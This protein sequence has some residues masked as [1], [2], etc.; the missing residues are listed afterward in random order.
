ME[1]K[2]NMGFATGTGPD[3]VRYVISSIAH[4]V[5]QEHYTPLE[6]Y[7]NSWAD[8]DDI[9]D[10]AYGIGSYKGVRYGIAVHTSPMFLIYRK[11]FYEEAGLD[12]NAPPTTWD[13]L[14]EASRKL[15][16]RDGDTV[17]RGGINFP[18]AGF[19]HHRFIMF[20]RMNGAKLVDYDKDIPTF[21]EPRAVEALEYLASYNREGLLVPYRMGGGETAP[22]NQGRAA[23]M[24]GSLGNVAE[25]LRVHPEWEGLLGFGEVSQV[26]NSS[27]A[28]AQIYFIAGDTKYKDEGWEFIKFLLQKE[29]LWKMYTE[30]GTIPIRK[31]LRDQFVADSPELHKIVFNTLSYG[32]GNPKVTWSPL[33]VKYIDNAYEQA[34]YGA[35][36]K[37]ALDEAVRLLLEDLKN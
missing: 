35:D 32:E 18:T 16:A 22:F 34:M 33:F 29:T 27:F 23:Q 5:S 3:V 28:G 14:K 10:S 2:L 21:N 9:V 7:I 37:T 25:I 24:F 12:P 20:S 11:D 26:Q 19:G 1:T 17:V 36:S 30:L 4:R 8:K 15:T 31:S 13:E 6:D